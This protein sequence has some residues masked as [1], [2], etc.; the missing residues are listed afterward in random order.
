MVSERLVARF[1]IGTVVLA[2]A[3]V[4]FTALLGWWHLRSTASAESYV[5]G[6]KIDVPSPLYALNRRTLVAFV[7]ASC[8]VC[9]AEAPQLRSLVD[10]LSALPE[11]VPTVIVTGSRNESDDQEFARSFKHATHQHIAFET[12]RVRTVP[13]LVLVDQRGEI[14]FAQEG[15]LKSLDMIEELTRRMASR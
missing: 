2:V 8:D 4:S 6:Q 3:V 5:V 7:R 1:A 11:S 14:L 15:R 13:T 10:R 9:Q 12:L